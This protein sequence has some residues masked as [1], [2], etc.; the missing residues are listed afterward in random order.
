[1][2]PK[3][4]QELIYDWNSQ[5]EPFDYTEVTVELDDETLRD[6]LQSPSVTDPPIDK[7]VEIL[8]LMTEL[9]IQAASIGLPGA[10]PRAKADSLALARAIA[11][12]S[13]PIVPNCAAR[14]VESDIRAVVDIAQ[15]VGVPIE[16]ATFIGSSPIRQYAEGWSLDFVREQS[17]KAVEMVVAE[18]LPSM[19]VTEDTTR[20]DPET[21]ATLYRTAIDAGTGRICLADTV[22][23]ATP[24]GTRAL[25]G[26]ARRI[27]AE[28][29]VDVKLD[30][31]G[32][33]DR[34]FG[35]ANAL[36]AVEE[37]VDRVHGAALGV[38]ERVGNTEMDLLLINLKLM[39][40]H[41]HDLSRIPDYVRAVSE[42]FAVEIPPNYPAMG[43]DAFRTGTGVHAAAIVKAKTKGHDW[44]ADRI[45]SGI[46]AGEFGLRQQIE[47]SFVSGLSNVRYWLQEHGLDPNDEG[48]CQAVFEHAKRCDHALAESEILK[49][50]EEY[51]RR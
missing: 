44:L 15:A 46:P 35:L 21:L 40:M 18:G 10:G 2:D 19:Y 17:R 13:L 29:G 28:S 8:H 45:Y 48:L 36:A 25:V 31:H 51:R 34:G 20:S 41:D 27:I 12:A 14:T 6:G 39:G 33:R 30:W 38:G 3:R 26:W 9:G 1:M 5:G 11:N 50:V 4:E 24:N 49:V 32:H 47:V 42:A 16:V 7:K 22:G 43:A 23:H 37:G